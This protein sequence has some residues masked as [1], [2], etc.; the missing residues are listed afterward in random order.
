MS[1]EKTLEQEIQEK[2][3]YDNVCPFEEFDTAATRLDDKAF[4]ITR[5]GKPLYDER[6]DDVG[7]F[8]DYNIT[9]AKLDEKEFRITRD[10]K[11]FYKDEIVESKMSDEKTLEQIYD[12]VRILENKI[13]N[14]LVQLI[15]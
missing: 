1:N 9:W 15:K 13:S 10:G 6:Y 4:H 5:D 11:V 12:E 8:K 3:G 7:L 2:F 14:L